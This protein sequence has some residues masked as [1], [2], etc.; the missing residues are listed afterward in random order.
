MKTIHRRP[1]GQWLILTVLA[2][3]AVSVNAF[4]QTGIDPAVKPVATEVAT[5]ASP[6]RS[7]LTSKPASGEVAG[8]TVSPLKVP[9]PRLPQLEQAGQGVAGKADGATRPTPREDAPA[10]LK[11]LAGQW[12]GLLMMAGVSFI[13]AALL[14]TTSYV[15]IQITLSLLR[16]ALGSP[17]IPGN[18][19]LMALS[20]LLS[21][22]VMRPVGETI[23]SRAIE[24]YLEGRLSQTD[25]IEAGARPLKR[26]MVA[27]IVRTGH[28]DYLAELLQ[29]AEEQAAGGKSRAA[30][31]AVSLPKISTDEAEAYPLHVVAPAFLLSELTTALLIGFAVYLPFL[32]VDLVVAT[33]LAAMGLWMMPPMMVSTPAKLVLFVLADGWMLTAGALLGGFA[34]G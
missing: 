26:F 18:Q 17:S 7:E 24:P 33:L 15:R 13:P 27:Q 3:M 9:V 32:I 30:A 12:Q 4:A 16:Q 23:Y 25:A 14:M 1:F 22:I 31:A 2:A 6:I 34:V 21:M 29:F 11:R 8:G 28:E 19:V 10:E 20:L 5:P